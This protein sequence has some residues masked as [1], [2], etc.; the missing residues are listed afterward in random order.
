MNACPVAL[1]GTFVGCRSMVQYYS[2]FWG[3]KKEIIRTF[4]NRQIFKAVYIEL[5]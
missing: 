2:E 3:N 5:S 1:Q 4:P